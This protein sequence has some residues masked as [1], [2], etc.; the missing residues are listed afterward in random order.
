M[1]RFAPVLPLQ[2]LPETPVGDTPLAVEEYHGVQIGLKLEYLNL[3]GS[4][5]DRGAYVTV[6]RCAELEFESIVVDSSG[7]AGVAFALMGRRAGIGVDVF[8]PRSAPEGKKLLLR[9]LRARLH[10]VTGDRMAVHAATLDYAGSTRA[11]YAGHW[12]NPY[13]AHGVKT[14]A[15]EAAEQM[16]AIDFVFCP[17]GAGTVLLGMYTGFSE[18][19]AAKAGKTLPCLI[20]VQAEGYAPVCRRLGVDTS[21]PG[22]SHLADGIAIAEPPRRDEIAAAVT[23]TGGFGMVVDDGEIARALTWLTARGYVVEPTSAVPLAALFRCVE[24]GRVPRGSRV[25]LPLTGS[26]LKVLSELTEVGGTG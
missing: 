5:K 13:F 18:L 12:F 9:I 19:Y 16:G 22:I 17:V 4:F 7:N 23:E 20:A 2:R 15:Y 25:L 26:G 14:M 8:L 3:G 6:A 10:E 24:D 11:A 21:G 1:A